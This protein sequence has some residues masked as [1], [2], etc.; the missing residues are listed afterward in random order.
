MKEGPDIAR[1]A[2]LIGDPGRAN[3]LT[4]L[5]TGKALTATELAT[6][7]GVTVQT[8]SSHLARLE[9]G[10]L[11]V[12][13]R[14]GRHKYFTLAD[15]EVA[16][17]LEALMGLAAR[18]GHLRSRP[19]PSDP[20]LRQAR[21][22]YNHLAGDL[23][24]QMHDHL[25]AQRLITPQDGGLHLTPDGHAFA[26]AF[27]IDIAGLSRQ[28]RPLCKSCLDWSERR[29]HLAGSLGQAMLEQI[30]ARGWASRSPDSRAIHFTPPGLAAF[31]ALFAPRNSSA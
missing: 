23:G 8:A 24:V 31:Q 22:C 30:C 21:I 20:G 16:A 29:A 25:V 14:S 27:G 10:G 4:A 28:R 15:A 9:A 2:A 7:A 11:I 6:E 18:R 19:G 13:S 17:M 26:A 3:M 5:M 1:L 12:P